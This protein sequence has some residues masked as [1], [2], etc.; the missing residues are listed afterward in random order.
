MPQ[1]PLTDSKAEGE[2]KVRHGELKA[3]ASNNKHITEGELKV[4]VRNY[5]QRRA[6]K[7]L[8]LPVRNPNEFQTENN[9]S[10]IPL[11]QVYEIHKALHLPILQHT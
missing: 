10:H 7:S 2:T 1:G 8:K 4:A 11:Q 5:M 6:R 9:I 3:E